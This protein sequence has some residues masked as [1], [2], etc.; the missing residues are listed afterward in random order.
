M[1][2]GYT[3][4]MTVVGLFINKLEHCSSGLL[5]WSV[6]Y[7]GKGRGEPQSGHKQESTN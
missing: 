3:N 4:V 1:G 7:K 2:E 6:V 5:G